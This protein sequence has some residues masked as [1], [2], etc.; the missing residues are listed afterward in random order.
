MNAEKYP[1]II[2]CHGNAGSRRDADDIVNLLLPL[3]ISVFTFDFSGSGMSEGELCSLVPSSVRCSSP[4][5]AMRLLDADDVCDLRVQGFHER[6]D[7]QCIIRSL[8]ENPRVTRIGLWGRSMG[9]ATA[10]MVAGEEALQV[11]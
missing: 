5:M 3:G 6:G 10:L 1:A 9:A 11:R 7:L 2:Y 4:F 8:V